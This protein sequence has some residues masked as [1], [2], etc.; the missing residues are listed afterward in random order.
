MI[1]K[2]LLQQKARKNFIMNLWIIILITLAGILCSSMIGDMMFP[3]GSIYFK[4][5]TGFGT[6][7]SIFG[8]IFVIYI[9]LKELYKYSKKEAEKELENE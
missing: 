4:I 2:K 8:I 3:T 1:N 5:I 6:I 7:I 9:L